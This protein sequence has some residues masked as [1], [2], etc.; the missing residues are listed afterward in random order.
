MKSYFGGKNGSGVYQQ[1]INLIPP[2][3]VYIETHLGGAAIL[4]QKKPAKLNIGIDLD[5]T[6]IDHWNNSG[7]NNVTWLNTDSLSWLQQYQFTGNEFIY[8]DPPYL[9]STRKSNHRYRFDYTD[10]QH[11]ALLQLLKSLPCNVMVSGYP[12][13]LYD[14]LLAGWETHTYQS[15]TRGGWSAT[16]KLWMNYSKPKVLHDYSYVGTNYRERERIK[17]KKLRWIDRLNNMDAVEKQTLIDAISETQPKTIEKKST[18]KLV[19]SL[20]PGVDLLS[21]PFE[22]RGFSV[23]RGPDLIFGGDIRHFHAPSDTFDGIIAGPPCQEFSALHRTEKT[24][25]SQAMVAELKRV[26][27][28]AQPSWWV[29]ENVAGVPDI[30]LPGY[31]WQ[32]FE[33]DLAWYTEYSRLRHIQFGS[34]MGVLLDPPKKPKN[35]V[36]GSA[37][38]AT[39]DRSFT[40][41]KFIQGLPDDFDLP[42]FTVQ[43][44]KRAIGNAVPVQLATGIA[45]LIDHQIY[46]EAG[47]FALPIENEFRHRC[48]CGCGRKLVGNK[49]Y[50]SPACRKRAQRRRDKLQSDYLSAGQ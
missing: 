49:K 39:D 25:Y 46:G 24:G 22:Q 19:L 42:E 44:K 13:E 8:C 28:E 17:R 23:V 41:M 43:G 12:S 9:H 38:L 35:T 15:Q 16:E 50:F 3:E 14:D 11:I 4:S 40:E 30:K 33:L 47:Q 7:I 26:I 36:K 18:N 5:S 48:S 27:L 37:V 45:Q 31:T 1:I 21:R 2:H 20:F 6:V 32:R 10:Q 34:K 29:V